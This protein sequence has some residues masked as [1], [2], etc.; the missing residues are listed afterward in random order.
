MEENAQFKIEQECQSSLIKKL[1][2]DHEKEL[3]E[4]KEEETKKSQELFNKSK[5]DHKREIRTKT[6]ELARERNK[7]RELSEELK[8]E[9]KALLELKKTT[10]FSR[11]GQLNGLG[12]FFVGCEFF[13]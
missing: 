2:E 9:Q 10:I 8:I 4:Q 3:T 12:K 11:A 13:N 5:E 1:K 6:D 7:S